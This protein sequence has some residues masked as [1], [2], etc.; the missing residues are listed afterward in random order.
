M[1]I[2]NDNYDAVRK[3][4]PLLDGR[5]ALEVNGTPNPGVFMEDLVGRLK[6]IRSRM[7]GSEPIPMD[8][9]AFYDEQG[10]ANMTQADRDRAA[11]T[12]KQELS[13]GDNG[14]KLGD[15]FSNLKVAN[16]PV[17]ITDDVDERS[18]E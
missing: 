16:V 11:Q 12:K 1:N 17:D 10:L 7:D 6:S 18:W 8:S 5:S 4:F 2:Y 15:L 9:K 14:V 13:A 3:S